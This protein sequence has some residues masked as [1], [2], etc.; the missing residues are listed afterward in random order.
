MYSEYFFTIC[1]NFVYYYIKKYWE[2]SNHHYKVFQN[3]L[4]TFHNLSD[5]GKQYLIGKFYKYIRKNYNLNN[6][7]FKQLYKNF[8]T[9]YGSDIF[10]SG[11]SKKQYSEFRLKNPNY[12]D[13]IN[14]RLPNVDHFIVVMFKE[15]VRFFYNNAKFIN[16]S[17]SVILNNIYENVKISV[18][19]FLPLNDILLLQKKVLENVDE[20]SVSES[21][22]KEDVKEINMEENKVDNS[23]SLE[24]LSEKESD[25]NTSF[26]NKLKSIYA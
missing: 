10:Q 5:E 9:E 6:N 2:D 19:K 13:K 26:E 25:E 11:V 23:D 16:K 7:E 20:I 1:K 15:S 4:L 8:F 14:F 3:Q 17:R 18:Y 22:E 21:D 24:Y 12:M